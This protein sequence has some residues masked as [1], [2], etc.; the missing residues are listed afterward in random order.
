MEHVAAKIEKRYGMTGPGAS[1]GEE[2]I[3]LKKKVVKPKFNEL[4]YLNKLE[5]SQHTGQYKV[6]LAKEKAKELTMEGDFNEM[7]FM[8]TFYWAAYYGK[9]N[10]VI[11]YMV[12]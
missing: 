7:A 12:L 8:R 10:F 6:Q 2:K 11:G 5:K 9:V 3:D 4:E 1:E